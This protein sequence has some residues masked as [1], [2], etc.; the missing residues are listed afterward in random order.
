M[1]IS[2]GEIP[3]SILHVLIF[4]PYITHLWGAMHAQTLLHRPPVQPALILWLGLDV[5]RATHAV[6]EMQLLHK[7]VVRLGEGPALAEERERG[8]DVEGEGW[9]CGGV[10]VGVGEGGVEGAAPRVPEQVGE[11]H[12]CGA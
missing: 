7:A 9:D 5:V 4:E 2:R 12:G 1:E 11:D 10:G 3:L 8:G 6:V